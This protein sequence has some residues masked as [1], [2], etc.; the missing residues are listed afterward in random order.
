MG[1][2]RLYHALFLS[3]VWLG[4]QAALDFYLRRGYDLLNASELRKDFA[5]DRR[6]RPVQLLGRTFYLAANLPE[7]PAG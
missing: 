7:E 3:R 6:G 5:A 4:N 1:V 2:L